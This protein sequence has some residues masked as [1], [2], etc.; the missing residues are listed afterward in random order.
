MM[1]IAVAA[2]LLL[3]PAA[4]S[5]ASIEEKAVLCGACHG[6]KGVPED[7]S[8]PIIWG[9]NAGYLYLQFRDF[10][11]GAR[12]DERMSAVAKNVVKQDALAL[13]EYFAARPWPATGAPAASKADADAA[14]VAIKSVVCTSCH[15]EEFQGNSSVPRLAGQ[16][17]DYLLKTMTEFQTRARGNNPG[18]SDL[19]NTV[20]PAQL[21]AIAAYLA[22]L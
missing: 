14:M 21:S 22:G 2:L 12:T 3:V 5:G 15:L 8:V 20:T 11:K 9:Q 18:M 4:A 17:R 19:M 13:A 16:Q 6:L 1:R 10:Q 7:K